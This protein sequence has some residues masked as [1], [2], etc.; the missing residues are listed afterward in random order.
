MSFNARIVL[1]LVVIGNIRDVKR[2]ATKGTERDAGTTMV[3]INLGDVVSMFA[4]GINDCED[5]ISVSFM[6]VE[7]I[8]ENNVRVFS[9]AILIVDVKNVV[10]GTEGGVLVSYNLV[11]VDDVL[12]THNAFMRTTIIPMV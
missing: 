9:A 6:L 8:A 12:F 10:L 5:P 11:M 3:K 7:H 2:I 4:I 1:V